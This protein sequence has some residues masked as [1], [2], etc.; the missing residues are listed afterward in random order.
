MLEVKREKN[1]GVLASSEAAL[2]GLQTLL[3]C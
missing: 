1:K 2:L 3:S